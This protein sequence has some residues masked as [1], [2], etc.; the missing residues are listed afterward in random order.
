LR[1][2]ESIAKIAA[3]LNGFQA[4]IENPPK[5]AD[6]PFYKSKYTPLADLIKHCRPILAKHG[7]SVFQSA[8]GDG[9]KVSII[10][11]LM[12]TSGEWIESCPLFLTP[13]K[14]DPQ[15]MGGAITYG[16]RYSYS[17]ALGVASEDDDDGNHASDK[18]KQGQKMA[19]PPPKV[20]K[21]D[22]TSKQKKDKPVLSPDKVQRLEALRKQK[23]ITEEQHQQALKFYKV[24]SVEYLSEKN[25]QH[26]IKHLEAQPLQEVT[27]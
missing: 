23:G 25:Y 1:T 20:S 10:T 3:A 6:N 14:K 9:E 27:A 16:C 11:L 17:A 18:G 26:Y 19:D 4:E 8:S 21:D 24:A 12:H 5:T 2:S 7:L 13:Q 15:S 22:D